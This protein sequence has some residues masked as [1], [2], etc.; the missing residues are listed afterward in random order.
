MLTHYSGV[1]PRATA[2]PPEER[3]RQILDAAEP[4]LRQHGRSVSTRQIARAAGVAEGTLFRVFDNK[5]DLIN[6]T[7]IR[8]LEAQRTVDQLQSIDTDLELEDKLVQIATALQQRLRETFGLL[9]SLGPPTDATEEDQRAFGAFMNEQNQLTTAAVARLIDSD[10]DKLI[11]TTDQTVQLLAT[12]ILTVSHPMTARTH[13]VSHLS[14]DPA[15]LV[16]L[17][18]HGALVDSARTTQ[19][20]DHRAADPAPLDLSVCS[21]TP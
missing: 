2:L 7:V 13:G 9:H 3:R 4:L 15:A 21:A 20:F 5:A 10:R 11:L 18:L 17:I 19:R 14:T 1:V 16:D 6:Q 8:S 12:V